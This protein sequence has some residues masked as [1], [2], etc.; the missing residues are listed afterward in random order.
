MLTDYPIPD[1]SNEPHLYEIYDHAWRPIAKM[2]KAEIDLFT[3]E[4][5][6]WFASYMCEKYPDFKRLVEA[7][8]VETA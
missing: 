4:S 5:P 7:D 3:G 6:S 8:L 1:Q 2:T